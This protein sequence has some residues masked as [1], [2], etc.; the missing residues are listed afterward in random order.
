M[1]YLYSFVADSVSLFEHI[2][3]TVFFQINGKIKFF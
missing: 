3:N 2:F 1:L